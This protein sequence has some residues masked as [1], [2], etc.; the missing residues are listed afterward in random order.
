MGAVGIQNDSRCKEN[1]KCSLLSFVIKGNGQSWEIVVGFL[2]FVFC[3]TMG[4]IR[5]YLYIRGVLQ[6]GNN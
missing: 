4:E 3:L 5:A 2:F 1:S 6:K